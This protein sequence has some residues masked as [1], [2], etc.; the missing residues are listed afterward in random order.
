MTGS[1]GH[2]RSPAP[3]EDAFDSFRGRSAGRSRWPGL[4]PS[5]HPDPLLRVGPDRLFE[6]FR[7]KGRQCVDRLV[8]GNV[9]K[10]ANGRREEGAMMGSVRK[11]VAQ[12][13]N[14]RDFETEGKSGET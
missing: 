9:Q 13:G 4:P 3:W 10:G 14:D 11:P 8:L 1:G 7:V 6:E 2:L 12:G 5:V